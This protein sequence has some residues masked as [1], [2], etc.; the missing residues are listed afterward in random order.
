MEI[1]LCDLSLGSWSGNK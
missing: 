1:R